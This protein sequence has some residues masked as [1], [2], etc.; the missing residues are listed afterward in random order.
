MEVSRGSNPVPNGATDSIA[1]STVG[2]GIPLSYTIENSGSATLDLATPVAQPVVASNCTA[3]ITAQPSNTVGAFS[4][5]TMIVTVTP[6]GAGPFSC[7]VS[8]DNN[9]TFNNP[10]FWTISGSATVPTPQMGVSRAGLPIANGATDAVGTVAGGIAQNLTYTIENSG[11]APLNLT[12]SPVTVSLAAGTNVSSVVLSSAPATPVAVSGST[13]FIV[14]YTLTGSGA[15]DFSI[16]VA[17]DDPSANPYAWTVSGSVASGTPEMDLT[18][19]SVDVLTGSDDDVGNLEAGQSLDL[20]YVIENNGTAAL[21][22]TGSPVIG[23]SGTTNCTALISQ[24]PAT[25][26]ISP[27]TSESFVVEVTPSGAGAFNL[28]LIIANNDSNEDPYVWTVSGVGETSKSGGSGGGDEDDESCT[29]SDDSS[30]VF[31]FAVALTA[32]LA[33]Y[34]L[35]RRRQDSHTTSGSAV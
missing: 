20:T 6:S 34:R 30:R 28:T 22:L 24:Q 27:S 21:N 32:L 1:G 4:N 23:I 3:A 19:N 11:S 5:T 13:S 25:N 17:N 8:I 2:T 35:R 12:G 26:S 31:M 16:S 18:R 29:S 7:T 15:F 10:Y 33:L 14:T 9:T